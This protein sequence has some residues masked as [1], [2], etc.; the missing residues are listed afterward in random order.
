MFN[1]VHKYKVTSYFRNDELGQD[2][3]I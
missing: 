1:F 2:S 3:S